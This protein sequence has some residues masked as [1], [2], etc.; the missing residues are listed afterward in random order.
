MGYRGRPRRSSFYTIWMY[1]LK[2]EPVHTKVFK[3]IKIPTVVVVV[4]GSFSIV[5][6]FKS[7]SL[8]KGISA[9]LDIKNIDFVHAY[10]SCIFG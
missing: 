3:I 6:I 9:G 4:C 8:L 10:V 5:Q 2:P 1:R 7:R